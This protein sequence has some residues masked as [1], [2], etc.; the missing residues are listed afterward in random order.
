MR[1]GDKASNVVSKQTSVLKTAFFL[2]FHFF[3]L[4]FV[5]SQGFYLIFSAGTS[6]KI[7]ICGNSRYLSIPAIIQLAVDLQNIERLYIDQ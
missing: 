1:T 6:S 2:L 5:I 3:L 7:D 4:M